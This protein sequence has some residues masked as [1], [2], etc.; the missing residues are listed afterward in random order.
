MSPPR[1]PWTDRLLEVLADGRWH[2]YDELVDAA[3]PL[4]PPGRA[5]RHTEDNRARLSAR[6]N[7]TARPRRGPWDKGDPLVHGR[8]RIVVEAIKKLGL[9][10]PLE[11]DGPRNARRARLTTPKATKR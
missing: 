11:V 5:I 2:T 8:R 4:V 1:A 9:H 7:G 10:H 3:G 6:R